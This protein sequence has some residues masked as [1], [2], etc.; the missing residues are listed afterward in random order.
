MSG[1]NGT[2][3]WDK[4]GPI[5][6]TNRPP[7]AEFHSNIVILSRLSLGWVGVAGT[8]VLQ[9]TSENVY[10]FRV[11]CFFLLFAPNFEGKQKD[12]FVKESFFLRMYPR[13]SFWYWE[14]S[15]RTFVPVFGTGGT[16][17]KTTLLETTLLRTPTIYGNLRHF[18]SDK[19]S[20]FPLRRGLPAPSCG[21]Q[22]RA[23]C[24]E[25]PGKPMQSVLLESA[26]PT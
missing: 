25:Q 14:T 6:G 3:P 11:Y 2:C 17:A 12:G 5:P 22:S 23:R 13:F 18:A 16:S 19:A 15:E 20:L 1:T 4:L 21:V 10:V 8:I 7:F 26:R 24:S 9:G